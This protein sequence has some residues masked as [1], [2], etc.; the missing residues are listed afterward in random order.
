MAIK[1]LYKCYMP[2]MNYI[3]AKGRTC[4]FVEGRFLSDHPDEV[5]EM[6]QMVAD[7]SNPH[8]FID[9]NEKEVD[10]TLQERIKEAQKTVTLQ[11]LAEE[12]AR[13]AALEAAGAQ[14]GASTPQAPQ[15]DQGAGT[16]MSPASLLNVTS[17]AG[18]SSL[19]ALSNSQ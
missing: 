19:A 2:S 11:I 8:I 3:T 16:T 1:K 5:K 10:T 12:A 15:S 4:T 17:S 6:D 18:L 14:A 9:D 7:K 13:K